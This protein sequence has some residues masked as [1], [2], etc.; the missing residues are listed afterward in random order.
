[1]AAKGPHVAVAEDAL[2]VGGNVLRLRVAELPNLIDLETAARQVN[3]V[4]V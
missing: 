3:E 4:L 2:L 1:M